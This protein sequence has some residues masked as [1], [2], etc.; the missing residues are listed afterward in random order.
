MMTATIGS[1]AT[2][3]ALERIQGPGGVNF[4]LAALS[5]PQRALA[6]AIEISQIR[7]QNV[8]AELAERAGN[9]KYPAINVYSE[10]LVNDLR[11]KFR[12][13]SGRVQIAIEVRHSQDRLEHLDARLRLYV[14]SVAQ[15]L[16]EALGDWGS[17]MFYGGGYEV[18]FGPI[19][20]GGRGFLATAKLVFTLEVSL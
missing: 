19:K 2:T 17:G 1:A 9:V 10:K 20:A 14:D 12:R 18:T 16:G 11:E 3:K 6:G 15:T 4:R 8:A 13:F 7:A 5:Q